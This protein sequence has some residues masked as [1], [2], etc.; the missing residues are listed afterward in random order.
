[1]RLQAAL[2]IGSLLAMS[3]TPLQAADGWKKTSVEHLLTGKKGD[4]IRGYTGAGEEVRNIEIIRMADDE[5]FM[6]FLVPVLD[7]STVGESVAWTV[8][9]KDVRRGQRGLDRFSLPVTGGAG[10]AWPIACEDLRALALGRTLR[11]QT[12]RFFAEFD[13]AGFKKYLEEDF[14][15]TQMALA[16][17]EAAICQ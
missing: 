7:V 13:L 2:V 8:D 4:V 5:Y 14:E 16:T 9:G 3:L 11:V 15:V 17:R 1:M 10:L 12:D 6:R